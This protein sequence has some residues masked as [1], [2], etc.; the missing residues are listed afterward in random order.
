MQTGHA[1]FWFRSTYAKCNMVLVVKYSLKKTTVT[2]QYALASIGLS[3]ALSKSKHTVN[4]LFV[5]TKLDINFEIKP[6]TW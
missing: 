6:V 3:I 4:A 1:L 5:S 2:A